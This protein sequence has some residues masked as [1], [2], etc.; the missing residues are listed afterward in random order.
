MPRWSN[1]DVSRQKTEINLKKD[2]LNMSLG[3]PEILIIA[4]AVLLLFGPKKI[5]EIA[6]QL[7]RCSYEFKK[8][9]ENLESEAESITSV[10]KD[11]EKVERAK[12]EGKS[13]EEEKEPAKPKRDPAID[14]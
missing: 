13:T 6:K 3:I 11:A 8:A 9:K 4:L 1:K 12:A 10:I 7:G 2:L 5:P 14:N